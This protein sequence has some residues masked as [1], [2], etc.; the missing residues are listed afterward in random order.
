M[1]ERRSV[2]LC[3]RLADASRMLIDVDSDAPDT[4]L[5]V[6]AIRAAAADTSWLADIEREPVLF[7]VFNAPLRLFIVGAVHIAQALVPAA[8]ALGFEVTVIDPRP[9]Y[10][11]PQRFP[12]VELRA[13]E[14]ALALRMAS[15]DRRSAVVTLSHDAAVDD[16]ALVKALHSKAFYVGALGSRKTHKAR[17]ERLQ[18]E[19]KLPERV[20]ARLRGPAGLPIGA[21]GPAEIAASIVA[22][23]IAELRGRTVPPTA[24]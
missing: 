14:P 18:R 7:H 17:L 24:V 12:G 5:A 15:L 21:I 11:N 9:G 13:E 19:A 3:T 20:T 1:A 16:P 8:R 10:A 2:V 23:I 22:E 6:E 4:E